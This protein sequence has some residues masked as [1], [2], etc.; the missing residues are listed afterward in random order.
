MKLNIQRKEL[1]RTQCYRV[2]V[3][4]IKHIQQ[5]TAENNCTRGE[6]I[7]YAI[8]ALVKNNSK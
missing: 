4:T 6:I 2:K 1:K 8:D 7:D 3:S 5:L